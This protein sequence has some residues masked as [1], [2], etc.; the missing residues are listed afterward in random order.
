MRICKTAIYCQEITS[1]L[2]VPVFLSTG[3]AEVL[4]E[5]ASL[6]NDHAMT[7]RRRSGALP[8]FCE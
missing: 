6:P 8:A 1:S 7:P 4:C 5:S 3:A 2:F